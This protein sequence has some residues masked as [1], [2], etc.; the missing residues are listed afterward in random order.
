MKR[1]SGIYC[2]IHKDGKKCYIGSSLNVLQRFK[3]HKYWAKRGANQFLYREMGRLGHENFD[4]ILIE[5]CDKSVLFQKE[6]L[7]IAFYDA[8][9]KDGLNT[10]QNPAT[11][12]LGYRKI[13]DATRRRIG[14]AHRG[15]RLTRE[16]VEKIQ[17]SRRNGSGWHMSEENKA[18]I[19]A[20]N[21]GRKPSAQQIRN[22][23]AARKAKE[24]T[25]EFRARMS[26]ICSERWKNGVYNK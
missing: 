13:S 15:R 4:Y 22:S 24:I 8:C 16:H 9:G 19:I 26:L 10:M 1:I 7:W 14:D 5:E 20:A 3:V 11:D 18:K 21:T 6:E 17:A 23:I 12:K 2:I 25:P